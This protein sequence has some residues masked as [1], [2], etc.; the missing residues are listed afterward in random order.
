LHTRILVRQ[1]L[2]GP[3]LPRCLDRTTPGTEAKGT[4]GFAG[5][6][7]RATPRDHNTS[8]TTAQGLLCSA[9]VSHDRAPLG[10]LLPTSWLC[11]TVTR[12]SGAG[13]TAGPALSACSS[14]RFCCRVAS[15]AAR[16][17]LS[18]LKGY[19]FR[20]LVADSDLDASSQ[21]PSHGSLTAPATRPTVETRGVA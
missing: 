15:G 18:L 4:A 14:S 17:G 16:G 9:S 7:G 3:A 21:Y 19:A 12:S 1:A 11:H 10:G 20:R 2:G 5:P 8:A 6:A 13:R